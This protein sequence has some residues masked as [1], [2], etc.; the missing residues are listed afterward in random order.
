MAYTVAVRVPVII[1][2]VWIVIVA[3]CSWHGR[4]VGDAL[5]IHRWWDRPH[6]LAVAVQLVVDRSCIAI[7]TSR[8]D[9]TRNVGA[10]V[11]AVAH[12]VTITVWR[13]GPSA[14]TVG[15]QHVVD[16]TRV[17]IVAGRTDLARHV[18]TV[19]LTVAH[20]VTIIVRSG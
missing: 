3:G 12:T 14:L 5:T 2:R 13:R 6:A 1:T 11:L 4:A 19:V 17:A 20:A 8:P 15:I 10:I 16:R 7:I 9:L 18:G